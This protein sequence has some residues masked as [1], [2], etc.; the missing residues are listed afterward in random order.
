MMVI[1]WLIGRADLAQRNIKH[2]IQKPVNRIEQRGYV[3]LKFLSSTNQW[4]NNKRI[5]QVVM[6]INPSSVKK[7]K[8]SADV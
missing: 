6:E 8:N 4:E 7:K 5:S 1:M 2:L 3:R